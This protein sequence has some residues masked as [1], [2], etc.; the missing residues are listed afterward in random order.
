MEARRYKMTKIVGG[1]RKWDSK[2]QSK[3]GEVNQKSILK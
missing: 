1:D 2:V 3:V